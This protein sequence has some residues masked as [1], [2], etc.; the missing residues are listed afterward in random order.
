MEEL[1]T[2]MR[3]DLIAAAA[4]QGLLASGSTGRTLGGD[5]TVSARPDEAADVA[6]LYADALIAALDAT[7]EA[8]R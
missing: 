6:V 3:R 8:G 5:V 4:L 2:K 7:P 1:Y